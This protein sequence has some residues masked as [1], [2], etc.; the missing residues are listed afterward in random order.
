MENRKSVLLKLPN[1]VHKDLKQYCNKTGYTMQT[2]IQ[3]VI[4]NRIK[5]AKIQQIIK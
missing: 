4:E 1:Q 5:D 2:I 3:N